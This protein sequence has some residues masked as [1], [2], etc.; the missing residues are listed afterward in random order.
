MQETAEAEGAGRSD[1]SRRDRA[2]LLDGRVD[3]R[4]LGLSGVGLVLNSNRG[5][6]SEGVL[7]SGGRPNLRKTDQDQQASKR[8]KTDERRLTSW[9][10]RRC[11][12]VVAKL[13]PKNM[14]VR[15][16][17]AI[18]ET[19]RKQEQFSTGVLYSDVLE[20][21]TG[22][23]SPSARAELVRS[24]IR[25][26]ERQGGQQSDRRRRARENAPIRA[27]RKLPQRSKNFESL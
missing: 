9:W 19:E 16:T 1:S 20:T 2:R 18:H 21:L 10:P 26:K 6:L 4:H 17:Q 15:A 24:C 25:S 14:T 22:D 27:K 7:E 3:G 8:V 5:T 23:N 13:D 12:R 11:S